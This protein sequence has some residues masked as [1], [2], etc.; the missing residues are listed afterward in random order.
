MAKPTS[1]TAQSELL[2]VN[3]YELEFVPGAAPD[4]EIVPL[5][6]DRENGVWVLY[7][8]FQPDMVV[9]GANVNFDG[10]QFIGIRDPRAIEASI[11]NHGRES[12]MPPP[13]YIS[14]GA[15]AFKSV[16]KGPE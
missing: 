1:V 3:I 8:K 7:G 15:A 16:A 13:S 6:L 4:Y 11:L 10:G 14:P 12:G 5:F 9:H 2:T